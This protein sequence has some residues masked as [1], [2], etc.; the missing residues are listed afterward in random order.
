[1]PFPEMEMDVA[2]NVIQVTARVVDQSQVKVCTMWPGVNVNGD[3]IAESF[4]PQSAL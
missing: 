2:I 3:G 4:G 1:M